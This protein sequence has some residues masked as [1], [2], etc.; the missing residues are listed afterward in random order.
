MKE[1]PRPKTGFLHLCFFLLWANFF[2]RSVVLRT[3]A[4]FQR[5]NDASQS[6]PLTS[7]SREEAQ[8]TVSLVVERCSNFSEVLLFNMVSAGVQK[9]SLYTKTKTTKTAEFVYEILR[10]I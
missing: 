8:P 10:S 2:R 5:S 9:N 1:G 6:L 3:D 7:A 4:H